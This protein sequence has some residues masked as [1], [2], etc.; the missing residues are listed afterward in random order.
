M[1]GHTKFA[2]DRLFAL[3]V[4][5]FYASD[6][7]NEKELL[8]EMEKHA[9][10]IFDSGRIVRCWWNTVT[11][12][13]TNLPGTH[14]LHNFLALKNPGTDTVMKVREKCYTETLSNMP[15]KLTKGMNLQIG[16]HQV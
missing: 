9:T 15:M 10:V 7:F 6:I 4:K 1:A 13:Y 3:T 2:P 11:Q 5:A 14:E 8:S 12:K 16:P